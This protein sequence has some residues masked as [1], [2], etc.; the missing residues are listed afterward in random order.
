M[1]SASRHSAQMEG[2]PSRQL[3]TT[4]SADDCRLSDSDF[5][6]RMILARLR[7]NLLQEAHRVAEKLRC[8]GAPV[9]RVTIR[10]ELVFAVV[11]AQPRSMI[12]PW[13]LTDAVVEKMI[14]MLAGQW[15]VE[16]P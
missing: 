2:A 7:W 10:D 6:R 12:V 15:S 9:T 13:N 3:E 5:D 8:G 4:F 16:L 14:E 11:R 1:S